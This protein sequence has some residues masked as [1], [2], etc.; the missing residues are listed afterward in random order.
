[1]MQ[2]IAI[3]DASW[4]C[5]GPEALVVTSSHFLLLGRLWFTS[6]GTESYQLIYSPNPPT[7]N[8]ELIS[9]GDY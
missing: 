7:Y 9:P 4:D 6:G 8:I 2:L 3:S 5:I 1:M